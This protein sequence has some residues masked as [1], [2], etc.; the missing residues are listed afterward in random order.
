MDKITI[1]YFCDF[2]II[3][4]IKHLK[5]ILVRFNLLHYTL[6][7]SFYNSIQ[8]AVQIKLTPRISKDTRRRKQK[9]PYREIRF[10]A[11]VYTTNL[12]NW[13]QSTMWES[14][15]SST[16]GY[17]IRPTHKTAPL[18]G[19]ITL[20][21]SARLELYTESAFETSEF[22]FAELCRRTTRILDW[23]AECI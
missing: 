2:H 20:G 8:I 19:M 21:N 14:V 23:R 1:F 16:Q 15:A 4:E 22:C 6:V 18:C 17:P 5:R 7:S 10:P 13:Q 11:L 3:Y 12:T 9:R